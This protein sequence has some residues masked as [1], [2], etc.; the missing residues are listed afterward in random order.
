MRKKKF[1]PTGVSLPIIGQGSWDVPKRR[2]A[3]P[4]RRALGRHRAGMTHIDTAEMY[5]SGAV[6][7]RS[8]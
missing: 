3:Q 4:Q 7:A 5:G 8:W 2:S 6:E 1:G